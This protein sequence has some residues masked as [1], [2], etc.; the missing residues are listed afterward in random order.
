MIVIGSLSIC[1]RRAFSWSGTRRLADLTFEVA[2]LSDPE[3][4]L[5]GVY[6]GGLCGHQVE[7]DAEDF[8]PGF[9]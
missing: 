7:V 5:R 1:A 2:D 3:D 4:E 8:L 9:G 6:K